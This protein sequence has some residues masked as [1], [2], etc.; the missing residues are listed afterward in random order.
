MQPTT[1]DELEWIHACELL[2]LT[3]SA[4]GSGPRSI[5]LT[6]DCPPELGHAPWQGKRLVL[7]AVDV[8]VSEHF[9]FAIANPESIDAIRPGISAQL[10]AKIAKAIEIGVVFPDIELTVTFHS[11]S[12][13]ELI[14]RELVVRVVQRL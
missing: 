1:V 8:F 13:L 4:P 7:A 6:F 2:Q 10:R 9:M 3:Y 5:E 12:S 11:G 14:C